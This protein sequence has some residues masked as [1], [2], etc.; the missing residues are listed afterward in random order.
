VSGGSSCH[1][2]KVSHVYQ[3]LRL[4]KKVAMGVIRISLSHLVE[5]EDIKLLIEGMKKVGEKLFPMM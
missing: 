4:E 1:R 3:G 5:D 2:G